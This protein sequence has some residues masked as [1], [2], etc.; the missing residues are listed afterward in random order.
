MKLISMLLSVMLVFGMMSSAFAEDA[1]TITTIAQ[2]LEAGREVSFSTKLKWNEPP[3]VDDEEANALLTSLFDAME[4][5][6]RIAKTGENSSFLDAALRLT[7]HDAIPVRVVATEEAVYFDESL[8]GMPVVLRYDEMKQYYMNLGAYLDKMASEESG[9]E[10]EDFYEFQ[11]MFEQMYNTM[12]VE[13]EAM[14]STPV[15]DADMTPEEMDDLVRTQFAAYGLDSTYDVAREW[16]D[17]NVVPEVYDVGVSSVFGVEHEKVAVIELDRALL[18]DYFD[19]IFAEL[20]SNEVF[21]GAVFDAMKA[22]DTSSELQEMT[23]EDLLQ[24]V[25][26]ALETAKESLRDMPEDLLITFSQAATDE[27]EYVMGQ[28]NAHMTV[29][30]ANEEEGIEAT[31]AYALVEWLV[32][33]LGIYAEVGVEGDGFTLVVEPRAEDADGFANN[34]F[35]AVLNVFDASEIAMQLVLQTDSVEK[36]EGNTRRWEGGFLAGMI[37]STASEMG[38]EMR[39]DMLDTGD[40]LDVQKQ[41]EITNS[42]IIDDYTMAL[43]DI[44]VEAQTSEVGEPPFDIADESIEFVNPSIMTADEFSDW[45]EQVSVA[46]MRTFFGMMSYLPE[47]I[48]A[49]MMES[50]EAQ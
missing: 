21:W 11:M 47:D 9:E 2:A 26:E 3:I 30:P 25:P 8:F 50:Q 39:I 36:H 49:V 23:K 35:T 32:Q 7:G 19:T 33:S 37:S 48:L 27:G 34:G 29:E 18:I 5:A 22:V 38:Y 14:A 31:E 10:F 16:L 4:V 24:V 42:L 44:T 6:G 20:E 13:F 17:E 43:L 28:I 46:A 45:M 1:S 41:I 12:Q 15:I 40:A